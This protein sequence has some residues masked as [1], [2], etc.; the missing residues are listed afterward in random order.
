MKEI[1]MPK[2]T[3]TQIDNLPSGYQKY[4]IPDS[5]QEKDKVALFSEQ[6]QA[7]VEK[8]I[9]LERI[10][11]K[12]KEEVVLYTQDIKKQTNRNIEIIGLFSSVLALLIINVN[13]ISAATSFL[14]SILLMIG[15]TCSIAIFSILIHSFFN[16]EPKVSIARSFWIPFL[17][18]I[19]L[20]IF[21][22]VAETTNI[23]FN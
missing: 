7:V 15:L 23:K 20:L 19:L 14:A 10:I 21:G 2:N 11:E 4:A 6:V 8:Q 9:D 13:I 12:Y 5:L 3:G 18:L 16:N 22:I 1:I 17:I